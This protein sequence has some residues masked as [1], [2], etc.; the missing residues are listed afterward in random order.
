[1]SYCLLSRMKPLPIRCLLCLFKMYTSV[2]CVQE[3]FNISYSCTKSQLIRWNCSQ[4]LLSN[5]GIYL[6]LLFWKEALLQN[7]LLLQN[8]NISLLHN[9]C[10][11]HYFLLLLLVLHVQHRL[12]HWKTHLHFLKG[13]TFWSRHG[14]VQCFY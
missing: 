1:M 12:C 6:V 7:Y 8:L 5:E 2:S 4:S 10:C 3:I 14:L 9:D 11:Y 13:E